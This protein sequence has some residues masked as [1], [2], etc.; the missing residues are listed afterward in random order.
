MVNFRK[1]IKKIILL[2]IINL[3]RIST[4]KKVPKSLKLRPNL[5]VTDKALVAEI[6]FPFRVWMYTVL[7]G[8]LVLF[9]LNCLLYPNPSLLTFRSLPFLPFGL[10]DQAPRL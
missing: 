10:S 7:K 3:Q 8:S 4:E 1:T 6:P 5:K 9:L 2:E